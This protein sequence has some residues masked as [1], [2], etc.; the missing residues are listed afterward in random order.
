MV[1]VKICGN[2]S[3]E[4]V[5]LGVSLG[6]DALGFI[7]GARH[8]TEDALDPEF[9]GKLVRSVPVYVSSVLVTHL[10]TAEEVIETYK[11][12]R[13][14]MIQLHDDISVDNI[15]HIRKKLPYVPLVKAI[16]IVG[17]Q[18][19]VLARS[20]EPFVD[21][22]LLDSRSEGRI[23][24]T[25]KVHDW[26]ISRRIVATVRI[27][28]ILAGGLTP[29]NVLEAIDTV[30]PYGVDVNSGVEFPNGEKDPEKERTFVH[31]AKSR[32]NRYTPLEFL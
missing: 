7:V 31:L 10:L 29:D 5:S 26:S 12:V 30:N 32:E 3:I 27:P 15:K 9:A 6:A 20:Y 2:R 14:S 28:V 11:R 24:G 25:G 1:R 18:A 21:A 13:T 23:G 22:L 17:D 4:D 16:G 19:V 8:T